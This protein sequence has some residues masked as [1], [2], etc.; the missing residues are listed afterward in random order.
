[1]LPSVVMDAAGSTKSE[2]EKPFV[3]PEE[4]SWGDPLLLWLN[5]LIRLAS[6]RQV[7]EDDV[8]PSPSA[9]TV[10][11]QSKKLWAAWYKELEAAE[12]QKRE[13]SLLRAMLIAYGDRFLLAGIFQFSFMVL[14][15]GQ[16]FLVGELVA[17]V[18]NGNESISVGIGLALGFA[19]VSL[20]C[21]VSLSQTWFYLR[22]LGVAVRSAVMMAVYEQAL[23]LTTAARMKNTVG[24]AFL[25]AASTAYMNL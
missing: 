18:A 4:L 2:T 13:P 24:M 6:Q 22:K 16:P 1:M 7:Q 9:E 20:L 19:A 21:S 12:Q 25:F 5:P 8:W 15:L 10:D 17:F 11:V 23:R 3:H 14:Q